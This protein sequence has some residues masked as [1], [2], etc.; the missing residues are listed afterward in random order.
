M[1]EQPTTTTPKDEKHSVNWGALILWPV[2]VLILY[3][4]SVGPIWMMIDRKR[5]S[6]NQFVEVFYYPVKLAYWNP[7]LHAPLG[8]YFHLWEPEFY[9]KKGDIHVK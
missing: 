9:D 3:V 6:N 8:M 2:V 4:L 7:V 5:M 1:D